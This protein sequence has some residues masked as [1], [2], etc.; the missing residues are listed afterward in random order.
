MSFLALPLCL[1]GHWP[2]FTASEF[3]ISEFIR[4]IWYEFYMAYMVLITHYKQNSS[5]ILFDAIV[6]CSLQ[7]KVIRSID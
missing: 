6:T 7:R 1:V 5:I 3:S 2:N 4:K